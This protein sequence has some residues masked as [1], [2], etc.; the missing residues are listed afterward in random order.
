[1]DA[2]PLVKLPAELRNDIYEL[3]LYEPNGFVLQHSSNKYES[4]T[5]LRSVHKRGQE[6][7]DPNFL[8]VT[9]MRKETSELFYSIN[10][11]L[12]PTSRRRA[13]LAEGGK[14]LT[15]IGPVNTAA[16]SRYEYDIGAWHVPN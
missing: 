12:H 6:K 15:S 11:F 16:I 2:S 5:K 13:W 8:A 9:K 1:M 3:V 14:W 7:N 10:T 4:M